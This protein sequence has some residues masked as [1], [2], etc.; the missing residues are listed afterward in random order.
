M[1]SFVRYE[2]P[3]KTLQSREPPTLPDKTISSN[4]QPFPISVNDLRFLSIDPRFL[5]AQIT[6]NK[7]KN[8]YKL[9]S[10]F[11]QSLSYSPCVQCH[12]ERFN[13]SIFRLPS[14]QL[15]ID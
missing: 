11:G 15:S 7:T 13:R 5:I 3:F 1:A 14:I 2:K 8:W 12:S 4:Q 10:W 6:P 9:N